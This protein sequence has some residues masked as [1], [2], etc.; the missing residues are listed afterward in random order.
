M[1]NSFKV[2][3]ELMWMIKHT[4]IT[5]LDFLGFSFSHAVERMAVRQEINGLYVLR[6]E[7]VSGD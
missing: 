7:C 4:I 3:R 6:L 5:H 1:S 2:L